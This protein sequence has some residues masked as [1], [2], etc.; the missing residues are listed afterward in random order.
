MRG[1]FTSG[2][3]IGTDAEGYD[4]AW[5]KSGKTYYAFRVAP[6]T[7]RHIESTM[8]MF[9]SKSEAINYCKEQCVRLY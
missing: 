4:W 3:C 7:Y 9:Q 5:A 2:W 1:R 8:Q 6:D